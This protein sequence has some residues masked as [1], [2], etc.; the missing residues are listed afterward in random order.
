M[1][2][3]KGL[4]EFTVVARHALRNA[5]ITILTVAGVQL[6]LLLGGSVIVEAV[7][8]R[9]GIGRLL[10]MAVLRRD[11][12]MIQGLALFIAVV[13][14]TVNLVVDALYMVVDARVRVSS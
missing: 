10:L 8:T 12:P 7:F 9:P 1:A 11:Y 14:M 13:F 4:P 5:A 2:R 6:A 3:A